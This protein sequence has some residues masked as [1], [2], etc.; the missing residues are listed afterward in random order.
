[1]SHQKEK[2]KKNQHWG[3]GFV[4]DCVRCFPFYDL[5]LLP[6][7]AL[8]LLL[9]VQESQDH[10]HHE[11]KLRHYTHNVSLHLLPPYTFLEKKLAA[12]A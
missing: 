2:K 7:Q 9:E 11:R 4:R 10:S 1:M 12:G 8:Y 6:C 5:T 3:V